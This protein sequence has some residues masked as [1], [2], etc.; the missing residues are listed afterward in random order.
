MRTVFFTS[1]YAFIGRNIFASDVLRT[2]VAAGDVRA[3]IFVPFYKRAFFEAQYGGPNVVI[4]AID[5]AIVTRS[6]RHRFLTRL[7]P[8]LLNSYTLNYRKKERI[9][10]NPSLSEYGFYAVS[11]GVTAL[12]GSSPAAHRLARALE[13]GWCRTDAF[14]AYFERYRPDVVFA[15]DLFSE[16]DVAMLREARRHGVPTIGMVRSWDNNTTRGLSRVLTDWFV[17]NNAIVRDELV[18]LQGADRDRI[19]VGGIPQFD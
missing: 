9:F 17:V 5:T 3:V 16:M 19:F 1:F 8:L 6:W 13:L 4:E 15:T 14:G 10:H 18:E 12:F 11:R 2:V 7:S